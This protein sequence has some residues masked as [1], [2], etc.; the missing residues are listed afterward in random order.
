M[1]S[2]NDLNSRNFQEITDS[3]ESK[4]R[5]GELIEQKWAQNQFPGAWVY[6]TSGKRIEIRMADKHGFSMEAIIC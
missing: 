5:S 2:I 1:K 6:E 4:I 3:V